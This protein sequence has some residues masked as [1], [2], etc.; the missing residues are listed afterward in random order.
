MIENNPLQWEGTELSRDKFG[1]WTVRLPKGTI[2]HNSRV[3]VRLQ[4]EHGWTADRIP[5]WIKFARQVSF[6]EGWE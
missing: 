6:S 1:V 3:K 2:P 4:H 5:A